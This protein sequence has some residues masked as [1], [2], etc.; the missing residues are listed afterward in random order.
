MPEVKF[1]IF[2]VGRVLVDFSF[3]SFEEFLNDHGAEIKT[4][5][6]F[7]EKT[8][9]KKY[10]T[11]KMSTEVFLENIEALLKKH[12]SREV[13]VQS[14]KNIFVPDVEMLEL[15]DK[16]SSS[17]TVCLLSNTNELHWEFLEEEYQFISQAHEIVTS[18]HAGYMKPEEG[19]FSFAEEIFKHT[20]GESVFIDDIEANVAAAKARGWNG[21]QHISAKDTKTSLSELGIQL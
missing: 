13:L 8:S 7:M 10:E 11:G 3:K 14:W 17:H 5:A 6:E 9:L 16:L 15:F 18:Y 12:P 4:P 20:P 1:V 19:I 21:I 2:D